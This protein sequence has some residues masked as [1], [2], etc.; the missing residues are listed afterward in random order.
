M[1]NILKYVGWSENVSKSP[2]Q[3]WVE[4]HFKKNSRPEIVIFQSENVLSPKSL[5]EVSFPKNFKTD[6]IKVC[7][8]LYHKGGIK[9]SRNPFQYSFFTRTTFQ[10]TMTYGIYS[11]LSTTQRQALLTFISYLRYF[12]KWCWCIIEI[13]ADLVFVVR[14]WNCTERFQTSQLGENSLLTSAQGKLHKI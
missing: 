8:Y 13:W 4:K 7:L 2:F 6:T 14:C 11:K 12:L 10:T 3:A 5:K 9:D 1:C